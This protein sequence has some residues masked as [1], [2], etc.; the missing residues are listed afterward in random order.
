MLT[1]VVGNVG[2][3]EVLLQF[4][5]A[6]VALAALGAAEAAAI[7]LPLQVLQA[8]LAEVVA[9]GEH[10]GAAVYVQA[11]WAGELLLQG[12]GMARLAQRHDDA[13]K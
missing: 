1:E 8:L 3:L 5:A 7:G 6:A 11:Q 2:Q 12:L 9:T 4:G 13:V 10:V